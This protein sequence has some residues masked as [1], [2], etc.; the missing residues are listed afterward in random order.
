MYCYLQNNINRPTHICIPLLGHNFQGGGILL[1][2]P[3]DAKHHTMFRIKTQVLTIHTNKNVRLYGQHTLRQV[4]RINHNKVFQTRFANNFFTG[5][6][7]FLVRK[8][9]HHYSF[10]AVNSIISNTGQ[11]SLAS[12]LLPNFSPRSP[13]QIPTGG[14]NSCTKYF[15]TSIV[16][17]KSTLTTTTFMFTVFCTC[18]C[19]PSVLWCCWLGGRKGIRPVKNWVVRC[20][21]GYVWSEVQTC[22]CSSWCHCH[23]LSLASV[24]SRLVSP[25]WYRLTWVVP[26]KGPLNGCVCILHLC[27]DN[28]RTVCDSGR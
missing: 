11:L 23:S 8:W 20:W 14:T 26:D 3:S 6:M 21:H 12:T 7:V 17:F 22:I 4:L 10:S 9:K 1:S 16:P 15:V 25:F 18:V 28:R 13:S 19:L 2:L 27:V 24:K 5:K